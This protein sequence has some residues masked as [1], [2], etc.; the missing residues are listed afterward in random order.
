M[1]SSAKAAPS[2]C[3]IAWVA[4]FFS[5]LHDNAANRATARA[6]SLLFEKRAAAA[7]AQLRHFSIAAFHSCAEAALEITSPT[8]IRNCLRMYPL[9]L[10]LTLRRRQALRK[11]TSG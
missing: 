6:L 10:T 11:S 2:V 8:A 7:S 9:L 5:A 4:C 1:Y 3:E